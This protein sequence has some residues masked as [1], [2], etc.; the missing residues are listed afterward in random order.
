[1]I[2][3]YL[4]SDDEHFNREITATS[5]RQAIKLVRD[6]FRII[7]RLRI[8]AHTPSGCRTYTLSREYSFCLREVIII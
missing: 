1:M 5:Y 8:T 6:Q 3:Y 7:G 4:F 2:K